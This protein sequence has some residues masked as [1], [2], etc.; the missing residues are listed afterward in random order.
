NTN[1]SWTAGAGATSH[2]VYF[3]TTS[4]GTFRTETA[5][6]VFDP[7]SLLAATTY[8]WRIDE[9]ND[10]GTTTGD[11]WE[12]TTRDTVPADLDRDGDVDAADGD[13]FESCVSGPGVS[14]DEACG[15][16]DFDGDSDADQ[17]DFGVLQRCLSGAGV[18]VDLDCAG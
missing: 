4:P 15:S 16:R 13:L 14:A 12:F 1:L 6:T 7:G 10:F 2:K 17:A 9:V 8:F 18:P 3:G 5:G 11:V